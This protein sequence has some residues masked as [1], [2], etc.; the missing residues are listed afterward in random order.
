[1]PG[2]YSGMIDL[3]AGQDY[4]VLFKYNNVTKL[5]TS[6]KGVYPPNITYP[7]IY[8]V[9]QATTLNWT[10]PAS[11][12]YQFVGVSS[13][14]NNGTNEQSDDWVKQLSGASRNFTIPANPV[15]NFGSPTQY[16]IWL[17]QMNYQL[18]QRV[19]LMVFGYSGHNYGGKQ[20]EMNPDKIAQ[21]AEKQ[22]LSILQ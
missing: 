15:Q 22:L 6:I 12:Q 21:R 18:L 3:T 14:Y 2:Y 9:G 19:A 1:M 17:D 20:A 11:N 7:D 16:Y 8:D 10:L 13:Y 4:S 5:D